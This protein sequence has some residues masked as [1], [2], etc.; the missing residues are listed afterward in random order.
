MVIGVSKVEAGARRA[1]RP[2]SNASLKSV[3][4]GWFIYLRLQEL[5]TNLVD[6]ARAKRAGRACIITLTAAKVVA[7]E[8]VIALGVLRA[9]ATLLQGMADDI[10][11][12]T[13]AGSHPL[14]IRIAEMDAF[15]DT[16]VDD[17][18]DSLTE[19]E[20]QMIEAR[21]EPGCARPSSLPVCLRRAR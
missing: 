21:R 14:F 1:T 12:H 19:P 9:A 16:C 10:L 13:A 2:L 15:P 7:T 17:L 18:V 11:A 5:P 3:C 4:F 20:P 8:V 6:S